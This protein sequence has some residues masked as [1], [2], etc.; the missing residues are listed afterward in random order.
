MLAFVNNPM[1]RSAETVEEIAGNYC[2]AISSAMVADV[3]QIGS[4]GLVDIR[5]P[6]A[7][8]VLTRNPM[9]VASLAD[10][11]LEM[12]LHRSA[13]SCFGCGL[14]VVVVDFVLLCF[15]WLGSGVVGCSGPMMI[16]NVLPCA[17]AIAPADFL[18]PPHRSP[19]LPS[20]P[21]NNPFFCSRLAAQ[22]HNWRQAD[23]S[24][25]RAGP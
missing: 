22:F 16:F 13:N 10:G 19:S 14:F 18:S 24:G 11:D 4:D 9:G 7:L 23:T 2:P 8:M 21:N 20:P 17:P 12:M 15:G 1:S 6:V 3:P 25:R 5:T